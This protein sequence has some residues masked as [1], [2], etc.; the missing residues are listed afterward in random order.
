MPVPPGRKTS[1]TPSSGLNSARLGRLLAEVPGLVFQPEMETGGFEP[2]PLRAALEEGL[3]HPVIIDRL[4]DQALNARLLI[5]IENIKVRAH[6][7]RNESLFFLAD[8]ARFFIE[9]YRGP[10]WDNPLAVG[11]FYRSLA[12][13]RGETL[14]AAK[15]R[16]AVK[17][18]ESNFRRELEQR[19]QM[20][21][22]LRERA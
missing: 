3:S 9:E 4:C 13:V 10:A 11:L 17:K 21:D 18:Y 7:D 12:L 2:A 14:T 1:A 5:C 6:G 15:L 22:S 8:A 19:W 20:W 16:K